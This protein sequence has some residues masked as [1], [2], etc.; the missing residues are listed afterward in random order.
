MT[1]CDGLFCSD[2]YLNFA[3]GLANSV[4]SLARHPI[5]LLTQLLASHDLA[6]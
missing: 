5:K 2:F 3:A 6:D 4:V 1:Y